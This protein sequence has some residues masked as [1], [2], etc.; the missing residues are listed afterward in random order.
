MASVTTE[1]L[2][3]LALELAGWDAAP[4]DTSVQFAGTR[5]SHILAGLDVGTADVFMAR[6]LG[7]HAVVA[8]H[9][10]GFSGPVWEGYRRHSDQLVAAGVPPDEAMAAV[11]EGMERLEYALRRVN[12]GRVASVARILEM[13]LVSIYTPLGEVGRREA[14]R[15]ADGLSARNSDPT[16]ADLRDA[17][18]AQPYA[19]A[20]P[21]PPGLAL[22]AW[23]DRAGQ[24][25]VSYGA[26]HHPDYAIARAYFAHG[27]DT[28]V[29]DAFALDDARRLRREGVRGTILLLGEHALASAGMLPYLRHLRAQGLEVTPFSGIVG[30]DGA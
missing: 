1:R 24:V 12:A 15:V 27:V 18:G 28:L 3:Q 13:P 22:G 8:F 6:Q 7:Y 14:Q 5:I 16:V 30:D 21:V 26:Y 10:A 4:A 23:G 19:H 25:A 2:V 11:A 20:A 29:C 17:F 9:P